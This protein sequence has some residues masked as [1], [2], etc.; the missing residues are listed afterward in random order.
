MERGSYMLITLGMPVVGTDGTLGTVAEVA[1][2]TGL[3]VFHGIVVSH[4]LLSLRHT[5]VAPGGIT[6]VTDDGVVVRL[7]RS[8][9]DALPSDA[10]L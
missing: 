4:G 2:D 1:A 5:F 9:F 6:S 8:E 3:D 10:S 7:T